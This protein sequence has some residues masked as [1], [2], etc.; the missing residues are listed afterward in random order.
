MKRFILIAL[1]LSTIS[2]QAQIYRFKAVSRDSSDTIVSNTVLVPYVHLPIL[3]TPN[4]D[5]FNDMFV[6]ISVGV[7]NFKAEVFNLKGKLVAT[8]RQGEQWSGTGTR[9]IYK[10]KASW[11]DPLRDQYFLTY[12]SVLESP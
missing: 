8:L 4:G 5:G 2:T 10:V 7:E 11:Y 12:E 9:Q 1:L 6:P 3:F